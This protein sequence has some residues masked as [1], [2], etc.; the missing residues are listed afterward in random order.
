MTTDAEGFTPEQLAQLETLIE[1]RA[2]KKAEELAA[3]NPIPQ[4]GPG[5]KQRKPGINH[6]NPRTK[7]L[8]DPNERCEMWRPGQLERCPC[9]EVEFAFLVTFRGSQSIEEAQANVTD[10][11]G[12][13]HQEGWRKLDS[14]PDKWK[15]TPEKV[16]HLTECRERV[17]R[18]E[19][20]NITP[21]QLQPAN[22]YENFE[23]PR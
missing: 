18:M 20:P 13:L 10:N 19:R 5:P 11:E 7:E 4:G 22:G 1:Q 3:R 12:N 21:D 9:G 15:A 23:V 6:F 14:L 17:R 8:V 2:E 16:A